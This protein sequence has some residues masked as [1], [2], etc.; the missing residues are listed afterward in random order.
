METLEE[1]GEW[2]NDSSL[3]NVCHG[4]AHSYDLG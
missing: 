4:Y 1:Q 3:N 2:K